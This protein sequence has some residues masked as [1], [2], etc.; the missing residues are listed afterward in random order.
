MVQGDHV[1]LCFMISLWQT[2]KERN[3]LQNITIFRDVSELPQVIQNGQN[4]DEVQLCFYDFV[5]NRAFPM[6]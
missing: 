3:E 6:V 5:Q 4:S 2:K 1:K